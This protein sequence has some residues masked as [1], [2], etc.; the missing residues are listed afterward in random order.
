MNRGDTG[1]TVPIGESV[2]P[3]YQTRETRLPILESLRSLRGT[4]VDRPCPQV[5]EALA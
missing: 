3:M 2:E 1:V 4:A 5:P